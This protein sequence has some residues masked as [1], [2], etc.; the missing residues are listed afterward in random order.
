MSVNGL[1]MSKHRKM[2]HVPNGNHFRG[3]SKKTGSKRKQKLTMRQKRAKRHTH[4]NKYARFS[5][6]A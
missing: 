2:G 1:G 5:K 3:P 6:V 4:V